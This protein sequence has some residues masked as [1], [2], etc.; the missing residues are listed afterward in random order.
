M[1]RAD[2]ES[3]EVLQRCL[4]LHSMMA[5]GIDLILDARTPDEVDFLLGW[6]DRPA[7]SHP[8]YPGLA[9][10][11]RKATRN[12]VIKRLGKFARPV[13]PGLTLTVR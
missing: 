2:G 3:E 9:E 4:T 7:E 10:D 12:R 6:L 11:A 5:L 8:K 13:R 1:G